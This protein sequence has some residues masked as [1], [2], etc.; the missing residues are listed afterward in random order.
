MY[1]MMTKGDR[2]CPLTTVFSGASHTTHY[3][4]PMV[5]LN[6]MGFSSVL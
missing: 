3:I 6:M 4:F 1:A 5:G 2:K